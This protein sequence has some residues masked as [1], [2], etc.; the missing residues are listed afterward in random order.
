M[1]TIGSSIKTLRFQSNRFIRRF[2]LAH[3][4]LRMAA[5]W[6]QTTPFKILLLELKIIS[7]TLNSTIS[8]TTTSGCTFTGTSDTS[9]SPKLSGGFNSVID[10]LTRSE[11]HTSE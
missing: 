10:T 1:E 4:D 5:S 9:T 2:P 7:T 8:A 6:S 11:E 3:A